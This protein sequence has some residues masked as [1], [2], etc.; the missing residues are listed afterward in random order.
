MENNKRYT[1][2]VDIDGVM[3]DFTSSFNKQFQLDFP[4]YKD[5]ITEIT[6][7]DWYYGYPWKEI[8]IDVR[9]DEELITQEVI[10]KY[11]NNWFKFRN[12]EIFSQALPYENVYNNIKAVVDIFDD[13]L[14][15]NIITRQSDITAV[16]ST[17]DWLNRYGIL[18]LIPNVIFVERM[19]DKQDNCDIIIDDSP[20]VIDSFNEFKTSK[21][22]IK[23]ETQ[24][25]E[26]NKS[27][28]T[29]TSLSDSKL[30]ERIH[31]AIIVLDLY[32]LN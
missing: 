8:L 10:E 9:I 11:S 5:A 26:N 19:Q 14:N 13:E 25:N 7:W 4:K 18:E 21:V 1:L 32:K 12:P 23:V 31:D 2:G 20:E 15:F 22:C 30:F 29:I 24:Y 16:I 27:D 3:R 28:Y 6:R 17:L